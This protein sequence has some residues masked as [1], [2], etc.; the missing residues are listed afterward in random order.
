M[1]EVR[2]NSEKKIESENFKLKIGTTNKTNPIVVYIEGK[3]FIS[4][5]AEKDDYT[6]DISE[7]KHG[8]SR[9]ISSNISQS[10]YF[11]NKFIVDFQVASKGISI[12]KKS[13]LSFQFLLRQPK[14][15]VLKLKDVKENSE[16]MIKKIVDDLEE[17]IIQHD[18]IVSKTKK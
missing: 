15:N 14:D 12:N 4:P 2:L 13:F 5:R 11:D 1:G 8:F 7:I 3:A 10:K 9:A 16:D 18:F 6:R 17:N